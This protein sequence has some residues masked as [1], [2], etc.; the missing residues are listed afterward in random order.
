L[1]AVGK[2]DHLMITDPG[3]ADGIRIK[4]ETMG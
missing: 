1:K 3:P 2:R 4:V